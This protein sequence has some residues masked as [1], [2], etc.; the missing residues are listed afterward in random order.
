[1][2]KLPQLSGS[3]C[4]KAFEKAG[5]RIARQK[6]SHIIMRRDDPFAQVVVPSHDTIDKGTLRGIIRQAG[7]TVDEFLDLL[8]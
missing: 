4:V 7:M 6:G 8:G 3:E 1:M 2:S 5:F